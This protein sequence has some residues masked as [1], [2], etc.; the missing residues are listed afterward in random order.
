MTAVR[1]RLGVSSLVADA[2]TW[3][4]WCRQLEA[5][6]VDEISVADHLLPGVLPPM[7]AL[8]AAAAV[9]ERVA[10][11]TMVVNNELRHPAVLANEVATLCE[12]SGG[13]FTLGIGAGHTE[14]EHDAIGQPL[15]TAGR[16]GGAP[17]GG[18]RWRSA[19]CSPAR[20]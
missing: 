16:T 8:A 20:R 12:L 18:G 15:A 9:T 2:P 11:S 13:R 19:R 3:P 7:P 5:A 17:R 4:D 10:L 1:P 14:A 6:G